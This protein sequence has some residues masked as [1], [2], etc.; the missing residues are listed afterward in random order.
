MS[1]TPLEPDV[2]IFALFCQVCLLPT[3]VLLNLNNAH[4]QL[5]DT[6]RD[7][8]YRI[9]GRESFLPTGEPRLTSYCF[10]NPEEEEARL[11]CSV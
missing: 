4:L 3:T 8:C 6:F 7:F 10:S 9:A 2:A 1:A 11:C 5:N